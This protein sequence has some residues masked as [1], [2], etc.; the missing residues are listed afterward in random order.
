MSA[1]LR[2]DSRLTDGPVPRQDKRGR[3]PIPVL[4]RARLIVRQPM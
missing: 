3:G 1:V 2:G 4:R